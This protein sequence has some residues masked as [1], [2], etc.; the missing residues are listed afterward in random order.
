M[1]KVEVLPLKGWREAEDKERRL[2]TAALREL[3][4][5]TETPA[6]SWIAERP[7]SVDKLAAGRRLST[8]RTRVRV[9]RRFLEWLVLTKGAVYP[10]HQQQLIEHEGLRA[11]EPCSRS[12]LK[13]LSATYTFLDEVSGVTGSE[14]MSKGPLYV[15]VHKEFLAA[16][17]QGRPPR[18]APRMMVAILASLGVLVLDRSQPQFLRAYAM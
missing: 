17:F 6:A 16:A 15:A 14:R 5:Y 4:K 11:E 2:W 18:Q 13:A 8:V 3:L 9:L 7:E 10:Q 1:A 12:P